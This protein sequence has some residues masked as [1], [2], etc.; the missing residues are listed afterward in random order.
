MSRYLERAKHSCRLLA[1]QFETLE[2]RAVEEI[3]RSWRRIYSSVNR[4]PIG[5]ELQSNFGGEDYMLVDS[6]V[7]QV[8]NDWPN[9]VDGDS[10]TRSA[11]Q[12]IHQS[13]HQFSDD[14]GLAF[15]HYNIE[16]AL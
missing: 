4:V 10:T 16:N 12:E 7:K 6:L 9:R 11:L 1:A 8:D 14:I 15:F 13:S 3:D 5:G 2:D